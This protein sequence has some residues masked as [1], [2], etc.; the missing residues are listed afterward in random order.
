MAVVRGLIRIVDTRY[1]G[2]GRRQLVYRAVALRRQRRGQ[3]AH[4]GKD[5]RPDPLVLFSLYRPGVVI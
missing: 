5:H 4:E 3:Q 1:G 2:G